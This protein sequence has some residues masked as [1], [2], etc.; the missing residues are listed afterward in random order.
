MSYGLGKLACAAHAREVVQAHSG[1]RVH[2]APGCQTIIQGGDDHR[3]GGTGMHQ[4]QKQGVRE[5]RQRR[6][7]QGRREAAV[8]VQRAQSPI[9]GQSG[10]W[11]PPYGPAFTA[12]A[13]LLDCTEM[14]P[15]R[16]QIAPKHMNADVHAWR[17]TSTARTGSA[18]TPC[19]ASWALFSPG[20]WGASARS[21]PHT[22]FI[23]V[24][25]HTGGAP[26]S[27]GACRRYRCAVRDAH[28]PACCCPSWPARTSG[29]Q[30]QMCRCAG[31]LAHESRRAGMLVV[32]EP[33]VARAQ[34]R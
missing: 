22:A 28:R 21:A 8:Q 11:A 34:V 16:I 10:L 20:A 32:R 12:L 2:A 23:R 19:G 7:V 1:G 4:A 25:R 14:S 17:R 5:E 30:G 9:R 29:A 13:L 26:G 6:G 18:G 31:G 15:F 33:V 3:R 24:R 27:L